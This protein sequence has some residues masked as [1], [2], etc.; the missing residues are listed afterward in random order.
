MPIR[1]AITEGAQKAMEEQQPRTK[2]AA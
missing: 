2:G 1:P